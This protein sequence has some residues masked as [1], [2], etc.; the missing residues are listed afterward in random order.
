MVA[1]KPC[2]YAINVQRITVWHAVGTEACGSMYS[3]VDRQ[4]Y[5]QEFPARLAQHDI[6]MFH[7]LAFQSTAVKA[8]TIGSQSTISKVTRSSSRDSVLRRAPTP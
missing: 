4:V 8:Q 3:S 7:A 1:F 2:R 6:T 5:A